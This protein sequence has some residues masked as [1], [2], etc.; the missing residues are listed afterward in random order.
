M[1]KKLKKSLGKKR[2]NKVEIKKL[3]KYNKSEKQ[4]NTLNKAEIIF[5]SNYKFYSRIL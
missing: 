2:K 5:I 4:I 1:C 3:K